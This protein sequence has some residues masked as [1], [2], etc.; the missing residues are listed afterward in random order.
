[1]FTFLLLA[2]GASAQEPDFVLVSPGSKPGDPLPR[3]FESPDF[4]LVDQNNRP[5]TRRDLLGRPW[6]ACFVFTHCAG[7]CPMMFG[8]MASMQQTVGAIDV[9]LVSFTVDPDRDT[10]EVLKAKGK[11]LGVDDSRWWLLTGSKD[12]VYGVARGMLQPQPGVGDDPLLHSE[13]FLL[14]DDRGNCRGRYLVSRPEEMAKLEQDAKWLSEHATEVAR[15]DDGKE[16]WA[17]VN[18]TLN[19][20]SFTLLMFGLGFIRARKIKA[21]AISMSAA[22]LFSLAFLISYV[23]AYVLYGERT[24]GL[25]ASTLRTAYLVLLLTHVLLAVT[26]LPMIIRVLYLASK[27]RFSEHKRLARPTFCIWVYVSLT[28][29]IVYFMLYHLFPSMY[30]I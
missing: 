5:V 13:H 15:K 25:P 6:V 23:R 18:A 1:M 16:F 8:K 7:P 21:H 3:L 11:E 26:V 4:A 24:S 22:F 28:G 2:A 19:A 29:I 17:A 10:P 9:R 20:C 14:F 30:H 12:A 27:R